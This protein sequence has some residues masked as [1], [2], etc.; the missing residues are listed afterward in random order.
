MSRK[1][2]ADE[3]HTPACPPLP[4][5]SIDFDALVAAARQGSDLAAT[6][7]EM[8]APAAVE[9]TLIDQET[10]LQPPADADAAE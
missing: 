6:V 10:M 1:T 8:V 5:G 2:S 4:A 9:Q 7:A 3:A